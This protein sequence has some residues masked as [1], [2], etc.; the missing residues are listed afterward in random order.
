MWVSSINSPNK[1]HW[2]RDEIHVPWPLPRAP[3]LGAPL[4]PGPA[5]VVQLRPVGVEQGV[6]EGVEQPRSAAMEESVDL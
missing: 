2:P 4:G 6:R 3:I 1:V 5:H